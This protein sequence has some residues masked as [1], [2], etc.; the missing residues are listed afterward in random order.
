MSLI[1]ICVVTNKINDKSFVFKSKDSSN[2]WERFKEQ[3]NNH[4]FYNQNLQEYWNKFGSENFLLEIKDVVNN[5][6]DLDEIFIN[7]IKSLNK[8]YN[9]IDYV[10]YFNKPLKSSIQK[11]KSYFNEK[12]DDGDF[13]LKQK[14]YGLDKSDILNF[15][16]EFFKKIELGDV[17]YNNFNVEFD[18]LLN[19]YS[20]KKQEKLNNEFKLSLLSYL[21]NI[22]NSNFNQFNLSSNDVTIIKSDIRGLIENNQLNSEKEIYDKFIFLAN[23]K[24][25]K[26][27]Y[28]EK[29][30]KFIDDI[31]ES[32]NFKNKIKSNNLS[33]DESNQI[34]YTVVSLINDDKIYFEEIENKMNDLLREKIL[35][36][37]KQNEKL[38]EKLKENTYEII[39][40]ETLNTVFTN[41]LTK[42]YLHKNVAYLILIKIF[43]LI[44]EEK[45]KTTSQ[46][47]SII[48]NEVNEREKQDVIERLNK[49]SSK[50]LKIILKNNNLR[51]LGLSKSSKIDKIIDSVSFNVI[52]TDIR[53]LG[54]PLSIKH[55]RNPY[56]MYCQECG[57]EI[58]IDD[59]FC[60]KCGIKL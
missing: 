41:R 14:E 19:I 20:K 45:I 43:R 51:V 49:L 23:E 8:S 54:Y 15:K 37:Q 17:N 33:F 48:N 18:N 3:L 13:K 55:V 21:N 57:A 47:K 22:D 29:C 59:K 38:K 11:L 28:K 1:S 4:S 24:S 31:I 5:T 16:K 60:H 58:Y 34:K 46:L 36:S 53:N 44:D 26:I 9:V 10:V 40:N 39:G 2:R 7:H 25:E 56:V 35:E 32:E 42:S 50:E 30:L 27:I 12:I 6:A 52:R